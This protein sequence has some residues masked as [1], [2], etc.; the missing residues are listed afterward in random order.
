MFPGSELCRRINPDEA[1][2]IG[3]AIE[4]SRAVDLV[5]VVPRPLCIATANHK[6][7][8]RS[9]ATP[10]IAACT[11]I[12]PTGVEVTECFA[13]SRDNQ[14]TITVRLCEGEAEF[15]DD[16]L[17]LGV[18]EISDIPKRPRGQVTIKVTMKVDGKDGIM[19]VFAVV[20]QT[21]QELNVTV[22]SNK[23]RMT[24]AEIQSKRDECA[25]FE[26]AA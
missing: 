23:G 19:S 1:I 17:R 10:V 18:F 20:E 15:F 6:D 12:P 14:E 5:D 2:V 9:F 11:P 25:K 24:D 22:T 8:S 13:N 16:N 21:G 4:A 26:Q 7:R 3:A